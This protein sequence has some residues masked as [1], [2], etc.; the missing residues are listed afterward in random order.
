MRDPAGRDEQRDQR[1]HQRHEETHIEQA[2]AGAE[3]GSEPER[4]RN[5]AMYDSFDAF[6]YV[7]YLR[8]RWRVVAAACGAALLLSVS[9]SLLLPKRYT[10]TASVVIDP[11]G[12]NDPRMGTAV[13]AVYLESL[14]SYESFA[15]S[16]TLFARAAEKF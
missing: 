9:I 1:R 14:K 15:S 10:A 13:S 16:D 5:R 6:E 7:D 2:S 12:S 8:K 3:R 4:G 11:P